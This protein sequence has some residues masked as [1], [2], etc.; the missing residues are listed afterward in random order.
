VGFRRKISLSLEGDSVSFPVLPPIGACRAQ[1]QA[2]VARPMWPGDFFYLLIHSNPAKGGRWPRIAGKFRL[3]RGAAGTRRSPLFSLNQRAYSAAPNNAFHPARQFF[4]RCFRSPR[5]LFTK[6]FLRARG[7]GSVRLFPKFIAFR[8]RYARHQPTRR[9]DGRKISCE[10]QVAGLT[11]NPFSP[12]CLC[13]GHDPHAQ[14]ANSAIRKVAKVRLTNGNEV[15]SYIPDEGHTLQEHSIVL[16]RG[17][18]RE[19]LAPASVTTSSGVR[20]TRPA[21][22]KRRRSRS[23]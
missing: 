11:G 18:S 6:K 16:V 20:S 9:K 19:G 7:A 15:I 14:E 21:V 5:L 1:L 13:A 8:N 2:P 23:K 3:A 17:R 4:L 12:W 10:V 22:E